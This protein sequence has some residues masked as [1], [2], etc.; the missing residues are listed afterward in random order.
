MIGY[1]EGDTTEE[2]FKLL[3]HEAGHCMEHAFKLSKKKN[4][5]SVFGN[6]NVKYDPDSVS[7]VKSHPDFVENLPGGY[8]Q[9]HPE[10][11][12]AETFAVW[13]DPLS[14]WQRRYLNKPTA[15]SKL[16]FVDA[17]MSECSKL[18]P[19]KIKNKKIFNARRMRR[20]LGTFYEQ[21][22]PDFFS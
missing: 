14:N 17:L 18:P 9:T 3:R 6:P 2:F 5:Q 8:A 11:D 16:T 19:P 15:F 21:R 1:A 4:W 10:E 13:L 12:F 22:V 20:T 7:T